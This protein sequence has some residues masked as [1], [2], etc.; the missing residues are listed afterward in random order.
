MPGFN[1]LDHP[2]CLSHPR[3]VVASSWTGHI[4]F[5]MY[6]VSALRPKVIVELGTKSGVSYCTFCQAVDDLDLDT[7]LFSISEPANES[8]TGNEESKNLF[9]DLKTHHDPLYGDFSRL[10]HESKD[11]AIRKVDDGSVDLVHFNDYRDYDAIKREFE[12]WRPKLSPRSAI[13]VHNIGAHR[14]GGEVSRFWSEVKS[15]YPHFEF[16]HGNGLGIASIGPEYLEELNAMLIAPERE[17]LIIR[18][19]F[20]HLGQEIKGHFDEVHQ[21]GPLSVDL[22]GRGAE[23][24]PEAGDHFRRSMERALTAQRETIDELTRE[25]TS[26]EV[27]LHAILDSRAWSWVSRYGRT[28]QRYVDPALKGL[29]RFFARR[30][31]GAE[32]SDSETTIAPQQTALAAPKRQTISAIKGEVVLIPSRNSERAISVWPETD[33]D[34][35]TPRPDV[36]CFSIINWDY[37]YQRPQQIMSQFA[38]R[39]N[40]VF[41]IKLNCALPVDGDALFSITEIKQNIHE[42]TLAALSIPEINKEVLRGARAE[43]LFRSLAALR[44]A[45]QIDNAIAY[46]MTPTWT[47]LALSTRERW[48][49]T[50]V[51]DCID[52]WEGFP[53]VACAVTNTEH[54]LVAKCDLLLVTSAGLREK[55]ITREGPTTLVRNGVDFD[56]YAERCCSNDL[57]M[58]D[59]RPIVGY[60]GGIAD[61]FDVE[62][63]IHVARQRPNY[64][65]VI[66]G[67][68]FE[69][70]ISELKSLPNVKMTGQQP[71]ETMP[72]YL[73]HFSACLIPFKLN[74][75]THVTDPVKMYEYLSA[76]KP[77]VTVALREVEPCGDLL[78]IARGYDE[79]VSQLDL[80]INETGDGQRNRR[81]A[82]AQQNTWRTRLDA[83]DMALSQSVP[84]ASIV[85]VT[86]NNLAINTL[87]IESI[88]HNTEHSNYEVIFV[89]NDSSDGTQDYLLWLEAQHRHIH[90]VLNRRNLGFARATNQGVAISRGRNLVFLNNDT[91]IPR[92]WLSR[93]LRH[94]DDASVGMVGPVTN[95]AG[96]EAKI[97]VRYRTWAEMERFAANQMWSNDG[98]TAEIQM[99][100]MFCVALR[101]ETYDRIGPLDEQF[102]IGMFEDDDYSQRLKR[103]GLKVICAADVFVHHFG[104][105]AF[106]KLIENGEYDA[107]FSENRRRYENKWNIKWIPHRHGEL[108]FRSPS[109]LQAFDGNVRSV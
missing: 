48:G 34:D 31:A 33:S 75:I 107:L 79:F 20:R 15:R 50:V 95:F 36:V 90:V 40:R 12:A 61:W 94:L 67:D 6:L 2:T 104:Q 44:R 35:S 39:G 77:V 80:A 28:R 83:I 102:G 22:N 58:P 30:K 92:G 65:F 49:W 14:H 1:P 105:A 84:G 66:I 64:L 38:D 101:R 32:D 99:L 56:F 91:V 10:L 87:C 41:H 109:A 24:I 103:A 60:F 4:P 69:V 27:R 76:G 18:D 16:I 74:A 7:Q 51:Y 100:A 68:V 54:E 72:S 43:S 59:G 81:R 78:F 57:L 93:L 55:W 73:F 98:Q 71:Y 37:R 9:N 42:V 45:C 97:D 88:L 62:L 96:N 23:Q 46:V 17:R 52:E 11:E 63:M 5:G 8:H 89:D 86:Y 29:E 108:K 85:I 82:F 106:K 53:G 3:R 19:F 13:L 47:N 70:D 21:I 26:T 25:L